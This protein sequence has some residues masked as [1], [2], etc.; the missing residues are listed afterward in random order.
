MFVRAETGMSGGAREL[1]ASRKICGKGTRAVS[2]KCALE[3]NAFFFFNII[4]IIFYFFSREL[5]RR[6]DTLVLREELF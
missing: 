2:L 3:R 1:R 4:I 6:Q 5:E